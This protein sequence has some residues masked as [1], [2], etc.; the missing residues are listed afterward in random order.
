MEA[1]G[2]ANAVK[3]VLIVGAG[4]TGLIL[5]IELV[6]RGIPVRVIDKLSGPLTNS[7]AFTVHSRTL[8][9]LDVL[10]LCD[11]LRLECKGVHAECMKFHFVPGNDKHIVK[12]MKLDFGSD[13]V[14]G[15]HPGIL[16]VP[17]TVTERVLREGFERVG[18]KIDWGV[19]LLEFTEMDGGVEVELGNGENGVRYDFVIGCDGAAS[20]TRKKQ[21]LEFAGL[22]YAGMTMK[23]MDV[24]LGGTLDV[25]RFEEN[26]YHY[27]VK[28]KSM[29]LLAKMGD[30]EEYKGDTDVWR[31]L[32]STTEDDPD[33]SIESFQEMVDRVV[34]GVKLGNPHWKV[35]YGIHRRMVSQYL[36]E[37]GRVLLAGDAAHINSPAGG[38]G[39]NTALQDAF[40]LGWKLA[41]VCKGLSTEEILKT[42]E[43]ERKPIAKKVLEGTDLL[44]NVIMAHGKDLSDRMEVASAENWLEKTVL[45]MSGQAF[46]HGDQDC[47]DIIGNDVVVANGDKAPDILIGS[48]LKIEKLTACAALYYILVIF[49]EADMQIALNLQD[50][51]CKILTV[52][53][54]AP[55]D[56]ES[57]VN[58]EDPI[59]LPSNAV[60]KAQYGS[61]AAALVR[62]DRYLEFIIR[63][64][65][66]IEDLVT[67]SLSILT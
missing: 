28:E 50:K 11:V 22:R 26:A 41:M 24:S 55:A 52:V 46:T 67:K 2:T 39:M 5:G 17:Q 21:K 57:T 60:L 51:Y 3:T 9:A 32:L 42:Y 14:R 38:Q 36:S 35:S 27:L 1:S 62:P 66:D 18:G 16:T 13:V 4:P 12:T 59:P 58:G 49:D 19:E 45:R 25:S 6:R 33:M 20:G 61:C 65:A 40:N 54:A 31:V 15:R 10:G 23:M 53:Q 29:L 7:R 8:E 63:E 37:N 44:Q 64:S 56:S 43:V 34:D 30:V 47:D 48:P